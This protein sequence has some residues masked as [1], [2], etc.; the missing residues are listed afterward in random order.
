MF[1]RG[2]YQLEVAGSVATLYIVGRLTALLRDSL[3]AA[4]DG[5]PTSVRVLCVNV[6]DLEQLG[7]GAPAVL[8]GMRNHWQA[9]GGVFRFAFASGVAERRVTGSVMVAQA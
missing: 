4:C 6:N 8:Q 2:V 3:V 5:L 9:R 7:D 1:D